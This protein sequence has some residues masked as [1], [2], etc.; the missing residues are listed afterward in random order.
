MAEPT[1]GDEFELV[2]MVQC[3]RKA[4]VVSTIFLPGDAAVGGG[5][6]AATAAAAAAA[7]AA[8]TTSLTVLLSCS[9]NS[10]EV[11]TLVLAAKN[12]KAGKG[13]NSSSSSSQGAKGKEFLEEDAAEDAGEEGEEEGAGGPSAAAAAAALSLSKGFITTASGATAPL[14]TLTRSVDLPGHRSEVRALACSSD[15]ALLLSASSAAAKVWNARS[16]APLR[17][18]ALGRTGGLCCAFGPGGRHAIVGCKD[19][20]LKLFEL[21]SGD[22]VQDVGGAHA[23]SIYALAVRPDGR[24]CVTGGSDKE[25]RFWDFD[26]VAPEGGGAGGGGGAG[27]GAQQ[28]LVLHTLTLNL[29]DEVRAV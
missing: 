17:T 13:S 16:G 8:P 28:L 7:S 22:L 10:M 9:D 4:R 18:L 2:G 6:G 11:H 5:G 21:S 25:C 29:G 3:T 14:A 26:L 24:G 20:S 12:S 1:A 15:G 23:G 27:T 19:G